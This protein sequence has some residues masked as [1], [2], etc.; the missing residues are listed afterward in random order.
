MYVMELS[1]V[2]IG[3]KVNLTFR[4]KTMRA[5]E[6]DKVRTGYVGKIEH[7]PGGEVWLIL[8]NRADD[9]PRARGIGGAF[10]VPYD[11]VIEVVED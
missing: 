6:P 3:K 8:V 9:V 1:G 7:M 4:Y 2:H 11:G 10:R 5:S